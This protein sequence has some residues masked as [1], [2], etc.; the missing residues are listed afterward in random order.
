MNRTNLILLVVLAAVVAIWASKRDWDDGKQTGPAPRMFPDLNKVAADRIEISGGWLGNKVVIER[1]GSDWQLASAGGFPLRKEKAAEFI[2]AVANLRRENL[3]GSTDAVRKETRTDDKTGRL[4][5]VLKGDTAMAAFRVGKSPK[6]ETQVVF[7]RPEEED[8][9]YRTRTIL[10][11]NADQEVMPSPAGFPGAGGGSRGFDWHDNVTKVAQN[12]TEGKLWELGD[13][14]TQELWLTRPELDVKLVKK[15]QDVWEVHAGDET[16]PGD[17]DAINGLTSQLKWLYHAGVAGRYD[18]VA[19]DFGLDTPAITLVMTFRKKIEKKEDE[20]KEGEGEEKEGE[21]DEEKKEAEPE[22]EIVKRTL[23]VG[24]KITRP[25]DRNDETGEVET[26]D[27]YPIHIG[28]EFDDPEQAKL[29]DYVFFVGTYRIEPLLK[30]LDELIQKKEEGTD[31][32][33]ADEGDDGK[34]DD[35]GAA[36]ESG[37]EGEKKDDAA[38]P[39][40]EGAT[41]PKKDEPTEPKKDDATEPKKEG[42]TPPAEP[43]K[44]DG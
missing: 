31:D 2:D 29:A 4:V 26:E 22:Y 23:E 14:E 38:E 42:D 28:G 5:R 1:V 32:G 17:V 37:D 24:T 20:K 13:M 8:R 6:H 25:S 43:K 21:G 9:V 41:E 11:R 40:K 36:D 34:K 30:K 3:V 12:W 18:D 33:S 35:A 27:V 10:S 39:K 7:I 15:G 16:H 19:M 44:D